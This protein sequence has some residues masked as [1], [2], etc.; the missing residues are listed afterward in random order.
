MSNLK[1]VGKYLLNWVLSRIR[2][3]TLCR[4][5]FYS[6]GNVVQRG[7]ECEAAGQGGGSGG[8]SGE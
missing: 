3:S 6:Y 4:P 2:T 8:E 7:R 5:T 1:P